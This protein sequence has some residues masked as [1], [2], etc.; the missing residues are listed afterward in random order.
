MGPV[1]NVNTIFS[2]AREVKEIR[3]LLEEMKESTKQV[4]FGFKGRHSMVKIIFHFTDHWLS[5]TVFYPTT[6]QPD[7]CTVAPITRSG[8]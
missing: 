8:V 5:S 6:L 7:F 3:H 4:N 1:Y 2:L